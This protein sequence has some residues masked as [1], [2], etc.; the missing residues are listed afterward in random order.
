MLGKKFLK[1]SE[2]IKSKTQHQ[3]KENDKKLDD[4][5]TVNTLPLETI[6]R[7]SDPFDQVRGFAA[8]ITLEIYFAFTLICN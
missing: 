3:D 4:L 8:E 6:G 1:H 5:S 2:A 7:T